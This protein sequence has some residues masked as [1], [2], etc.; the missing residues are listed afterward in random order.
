MCLAL[1][2]SKQTEAQDSSTT[3]LIKLPKVNHIGFYI[4]P[5]FQYGQLKNGF[6]GFG[7][8]S[9]MLLINKKLG[10]GLTSFRNMDRNYSP[11]G[12]APLILS[13]DFKGIKFEYS[14]R[15]NKALHLSFPLTIGVART[16]TDSIGMFYG[17]NH[18]QMNEIPNAPHRSFENRSIYMFVMPGVQLEANVFKFMKVY[19]GVNYRLAWKDAMPNQ[20]ANSTVEGLSANAG[21]KLGV[22][23]VSTSKK[24]K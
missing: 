2:T 20:L 23:E 3:Q 22:F 9:F 19:A 8:N 18:D 1:F 16:T 24:K 12:I 10:V 13:S 15:G 21:I 7:G 14:V 6:T 11:S 4:A 5:E 17:K